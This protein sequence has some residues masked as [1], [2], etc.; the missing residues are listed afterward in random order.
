MILILLVGAGSNA[1]MLGFRG[2]LSIWATLTDEEPDGQLGGQYIGE[3]SM[4]GELSPDWQLNGEAAFDANGYGLIGNGGDGEWKGDVEP[5]RLWL[6]LASQQGEL[7]AGLQKISFGSATLLRPL[8]WFDSRDPLDP[9]QRTDGVYGVLGRYTFLNNASIWVWGLYGNDEL[10]GWET[11]PTDDDEIEW[12][13]RLLCPLGPGE[14]GL[15]VHHR[16]ATPA[17]TTD[18]NT[19]IEQ[20]SFSENRV[21]LDGKW[22]VGIGLW[23]E[24]TLT[25]QE[26]DAPQ[27]RYRRLLTLGS[28]YT[29]PVGYGIHVLGEHFVAD[30]ADEALGNGDSISFSALSC[31]YPLSSFDALALFV[32]YNWEDAAWSPT[33]QWQRTYDQW[34]IYVRAFHSEDETQP[35]IAE[36]ATA[37]TG[38]GV[39]LM[40]VFSY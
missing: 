38:N 13:G 30:V 20:D 8:M 35:A 40:L 1:D 4:A 34:Q 2:Q 27:P 36:T 16:R 39:Q 37:L 25:R 26:L 28:D 19:C 10:R 32:Y 3:L 15:A 21:G 5:Y 17:G 9:L 23:F 18:E 24:G 33:L 6:R 12:G 14:M 31:R 22:D 11:N 7:R 29:F